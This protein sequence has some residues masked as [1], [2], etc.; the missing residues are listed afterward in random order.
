MGIYEFIRAKRQHAI[1]KQKVKGYERIREMHKERVQQEEMAR[2][3]EQQQMEAQKLEA[4]RSKGRQP[5]KLKEVLK[6]SMGEYSKYRKSKGLSGRRSMGLQNTMGQ[7]RGPE[8]GLARDPFAQTKS[9][10][11]SS[12]GSGKVWTGTGFE[13]VKSKHK[14]KQI[15]IRL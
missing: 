1:N 5:S 12:F 10:S 4:T 6:K 13:S 15:I 11:I 14:S 3:R 2:I 7:T 9:N 8:F